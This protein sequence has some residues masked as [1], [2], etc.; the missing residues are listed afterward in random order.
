MLK[1]SSKG[2]IRFTRG[3]G[4]VSEAAFAMCGNPNKVFLTGNSPQLI[5]RFTWPVRL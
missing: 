1:I 3:F 4:L 2:G 5:F